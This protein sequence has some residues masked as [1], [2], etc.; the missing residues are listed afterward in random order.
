MC[1][2][3]KP[4]KFHQLQSHSIF[5]SLSGPDIVRAILY[6]HYFCQIRTDAKIQIKINVWFS[7]TFLQKICAK[8]P[9]GF[10]AGYVGPVRPGT[11]GEIINGQNR[12]V[13]SMTGAVQF[14]T[15]HAAA[16][17]PL[18]PSL[19]TGFRNSVGIVFRLIF[20]RRRNLPQARGSVTPACE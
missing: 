7:R 1:P 13:H 14:F 9:A 11:G 2:L 10:A 5:N 18:T 4:V 20:K 16:T 19:L 8:P 12:P 15:S 17:I 6:G 3:E